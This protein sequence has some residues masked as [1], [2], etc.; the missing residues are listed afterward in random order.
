MKKLILAL[1]ILIAI[2]VEAAMVRVVD[3]QDGRT[4]V[5]ER[6]GQRETVRLAG[7]VITDETRAADL[8]RWSVVSFW[9]MLEPHAGGGHLAYRSPDALFVNRELVLRGY[10]R[11]TAQAVEPERNLVVTYLGTIDPPLTSTASRTRSD[12]N[13]R[14]PATRAP[15]T[16]DAAPRAAGR[17]RARA[18]RRR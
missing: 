8:L 18:P 11:A 3:V 1:G 6:N 10:A 9:V 12:T 16:A 4:L 2:R 14:S 7:I 5:I 15:K 13:R 17:S